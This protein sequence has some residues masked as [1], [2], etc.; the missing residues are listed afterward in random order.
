V[1]GT[2]KKINKNAQIVVLKYE[3]IEQT[4][5]WPI[6]IATCVGTAV[7]WQSAKHVVSDIDESVKSK[8]GSVTMFDNLWNPRKSNRSY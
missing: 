4:H 2:N 8:A 1:A 5:R 3:P 7:A 6:R